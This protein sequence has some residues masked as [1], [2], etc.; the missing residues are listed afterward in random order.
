M[1][2]VCENKLGFAPWDGDNP[3]HE[4]CPFCGIQ[5]G[6]N[7]ARLDLRQQI[8]QE[9]RKEWVANDR[10]PFSGDQW[11]EV[12]IRIGRSLGYGTKAG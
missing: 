9:W 4:I 6:Y 7:D 2:P 10:Q 3:S 1:C 12:S 5:F 8:Y 11:R